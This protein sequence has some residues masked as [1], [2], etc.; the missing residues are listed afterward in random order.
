[1]LAASVVWAGQAGP[2]VPAWVFSRVR[3]PFMKA[4]ICGMRRVGHH[5]AFCAAQ[6]QRVGG[7]A[8]GLSMDTAYSGGCSC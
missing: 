5:L 3:R 8:E 1:V 7:P 6:Q 2:G 4:S